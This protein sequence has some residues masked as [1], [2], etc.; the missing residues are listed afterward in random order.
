M[1]GLV[2]VKHKDDL[3]TFAGIAPDR[4]RAGRRNKEHTTCGCFFSRATAT[5]INDNFDSFLSLTAKAGK[6]SASVHGVVKN[7]PIAMKMKS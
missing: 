1:K 4:R 5:A 2:S 3:A 7:G 6:I